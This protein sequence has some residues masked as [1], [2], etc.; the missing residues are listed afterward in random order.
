M[1][2]YMNK[3]VYSIDEVE[4]P[5]E[6]NIILGLSIGY[7]KEIKNKLFKFKDVFNIWE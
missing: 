4:N 6:M 5:Q 2:S 3:P 7:I 1:T